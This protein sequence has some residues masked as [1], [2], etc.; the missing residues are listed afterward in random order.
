VESLEPIE[1]REDQLK[2]DLGDHLDEKRVER[3]LVLSELLNRDVGFFM[4]P[5]SRLEG[6]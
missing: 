6:G 2:F 4:K 1:K 5:D 3:D